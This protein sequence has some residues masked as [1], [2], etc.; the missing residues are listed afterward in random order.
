MSLTEEAVGM[1]PVQ[2]QIIECVFRER[3]S[4]FVVREVGPDGAVARVV[5][6]A[7]PADA[8]DEAPAE[9]E[10]PATAAGLA[11][12]AGGDADVVEA[13]ERVLSGA[14]PGPAALP[15]CSDKAARTAQHQ[16]ARR[17]GAATDTD[18]AGPAM[19][20]R[21]WKAGGSR[22]R[23]RDGGGRQ[24]SRNVWPAGRPRFCRFA[25]Y[26]EN[27]D[28]MAVVGALARALRCK[29]S[30]VGYAGTKD[31]RAVT[32]QFATAHR[33]DAR[34]VSA[35]VARVARQF[36]AV[37]CGGFSYVGDA[38][39][40]GDLSGNAFEVALRRARVAGGG[41]EALVA[42]AADAARRVG[43]RGFVN[44]FGLQRFGTGATS[45]AIVGEAVLKAA[46]GRGEWKAVS[47]LILGARARD[48]PREVEAKAHYAAGRL[49]E[50]V[51]AMPRR[52]RVERGLLEGLVRHGANAHLSAFETL[53]KNL[54][55]MYVHAWRSGVFCFFFGARVH[56]HHARH[57]SRVF[58]A[59]AAARA[60]RHGFA[61]VAGDLVLERGGES[62][63]LAADAAVRVVGAADVGAYAIDD[64]VLPLP[65]H[66]VT[67][68]TFGGAEEAYAGR[69]DDYRSEKHGEFSLSGAY[70]PFVVRPA[71]L[72]VA[73]VRHTDADEPLLATD[74]RADA[75]PFVAPTPG[76][77]D[78]LVVK[79]QLP[80]SAY[81]TVCLRELTGQSFSTAA[82]ISAMNGARDA[83]EPGA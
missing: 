9:E 60:T 75:P 28:T 59:A 13:I 36:P 21:V 34:T 11:A 58:N 41:R 56:N 37:R 8:P 67:Y 63:R 18:G 54:R 44:Y 70:R 29:A 32:T 19:H 52:Q 83:E 10:A 3:Y 82:H 17:L 74:D 26:K 48:E 22:K 80:S 2:A 79:F 15:P 5:A 1:A 42:A 6:E 33:K 72:S 61:V 49:R 73:V 16:Y 20:V 23:A 68:P 81:A 4:D 45:N 39:R 55:L 50:A 69:L 30:S 47:D 51:D 12:L 53:P 66:A 14:D 71:G 57:Q 35:A 78:A 27:C 62:R 77:R 31:R 76:A 24:D 65:G 7:P 40:L 25:L 64:V 38:L 46:T 43:E